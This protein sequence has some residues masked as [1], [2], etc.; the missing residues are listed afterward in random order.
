MQ[1]TS[2]GIDIVSIE[3]IKKLVQNERFL[4]RFFSQ[5]ERE[6]FLLRKNSP[7]T[8]AA[9]FAGKEALLKALGLGLGGMKLSE[10]EI[11]RLASGAPVVKLSGGAEQTAER[12]GAADIKISLTHDAGIAAAVVTVIK[13]V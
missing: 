4:L 3:R 9:N 7:H 13:S 5:R 2:L 12:L 8:V 6:Y 10:I 1:E 11:L